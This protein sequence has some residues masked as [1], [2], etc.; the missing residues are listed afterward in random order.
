MRIMMVESKVP[1]QF[2]PYAMQQAVMLHNILPSSANPDWK[3]PHE[4]Q[5]G[6]KADI[7]KLR[8]WGAKCYYLLPRRDVESKLSPRA[9]PAVH[10]GRDPRRNGYVIYVPKLNRVTTAYHLAFGKEDQFIDP[11]STTDGYIAR[12]KRATTR[13][14]TQLDV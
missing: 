12:H 1:E 7:S 11:T 5:T 4:M 9:V 6:H 13:N 3:S 8:V 14:V 2:W 10:L